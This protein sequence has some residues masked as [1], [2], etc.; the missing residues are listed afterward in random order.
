[1]VRFLTHELKPILKHEEKV[2]MNLYICKSV[3]VGRGG[4]LQLLL[5][6]GWGGSYT[7]KYI[8]KNPNQVFRFQ[9]HPLLLRKEKRK[10]KGPICKLH[11]YIKIGLV[12]N[13]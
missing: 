3:C 8:K 1:V 4:F 7:S 5:K 12:F 2:I 11:L 13:G 6:S 9:L 10:G